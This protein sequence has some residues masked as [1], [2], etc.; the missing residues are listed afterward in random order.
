MSRIIEKYISICINKIYKGDEVD[1]SEFQSV[2][3]FYR[4]LVRSEEYDTEQIQCLI[5]SAA[6]YRSSKTTDWEMFQ[7]HWHDPKNAEFGSAFSGALGLLTGFAI[8]SSSLVSLVSGY[9]ASTLFSMYAEKSS[10]SPAVLFQHDVYSCLDRLQ[11]I[12]ESFG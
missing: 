2:L 9:A 8:T 7:I 11:V 6:R 12:E 5:D 3:W 1:F 10:Y 4:N